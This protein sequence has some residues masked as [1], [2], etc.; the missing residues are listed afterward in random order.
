M[1]IA[2]TLPVLLLA[3]V[4]STAAVA[5]NLPPTAPLP[6]PRPVDHPTA[7]PPP[8]PPEAAAARPESSEDAGCLRD[9]DRLAVS[10][11]PL[12]AIANNACGAP[13]PLLVDR[14]P[15]GID[16]SPPA[17]MTCPVAR[18]LAQWTLEV[19]SAEA[20]GTL[21]ARLSAI[22]IGTSYE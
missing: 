6:P 8:S 16:V 22:Q 20:D 3:V 12:P 19:V 11:K 15:D 4:V 21:A 17:T 5:G 2:G 1:R 14:L 13:H 10:Y 9:L 18:A 7:P